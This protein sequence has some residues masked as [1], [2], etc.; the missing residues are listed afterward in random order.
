M[1]KLWKYFL[2]GYLWAMTSSMIAF[3]IAVVFYRAT[4]WR[5]SDGCLEGIGGD[6]MWGHPGAQCVGNVIVYKDERHR[7]HD[8][9]R[10]HERVHAWQSMILGPLFLPV[11]FA[12]WGVL[13][14]RFRDGWKTYWRHPMEVW[15]YRLMG[16]ED[17]WG[18]STKKP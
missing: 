18:R 2:P 15:A 13:W 12:I 9:V 5:W 17:A 6:R 11:Y 3:T 8:D 7:A 1:N 14:L 4:D 10:A 16:N